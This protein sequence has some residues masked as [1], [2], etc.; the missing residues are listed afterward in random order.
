MTKCKDSVDVCYF[1]LSVLGF[2]VLLQP[3]AHYFSKI[4]F[5]RVELSTTLILLIKHSTR[6]CV[7]HNNTRMHVIQCENGMFA[8]AYWN[9]HKNEMLTFA[10]AYHLIRHKINFAHLSSDKFGL[11]FICSA[12]SSA[13]SS[14]IISPR[15]SI[16]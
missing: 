8:H 13:S 14:V 12:M 3:C 7:Y 5:F 1:S 16:L 10:S 4:H 6:T 2:V 15:R 11:S 9:D